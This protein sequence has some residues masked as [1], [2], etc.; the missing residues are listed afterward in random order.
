MKISKTILTFDN[1]NIEKCTY[2][3]SDSQI[4]INKVN[5]EKQISKKFSCDKN[6]FKCFIGLRC[7]AKIQP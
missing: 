3:C 2:H 7:R 4:S 5:I 6:F 1:I